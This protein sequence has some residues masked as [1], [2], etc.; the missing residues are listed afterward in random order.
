MKSGN[1]GVEATM[2][3]APNYRDVEGRVLATWPDD[4]T[5]HL[6]LLDALE[7][8]L[9]RQTDDSRKASILHDSLA[10][11]T[12]PAKSRHVSRAE[13]PTSLQ[14]LGND[15]SL[16]RC[17]RQSMLLTGWPSRLMKKIHWTWEASCHGIRHWRFHHCK[18]SIVISIVQSFEV[19]GRCWFS[20]AVCFSFYGMPGSV[21]LFRL[22]WLRIMSTRLSRL[23]H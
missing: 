8:A 6:D 14:Q 5:W 23:A 10:A 16:L 22:A 20:L 9:Y 1:R 3:I 13:A 12:L 7:D 15:C 4:E 2:Y 18:W 21:I 11:S 17:S 19:I